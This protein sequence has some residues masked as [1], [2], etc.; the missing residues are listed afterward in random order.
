MRPRDRTF[1]QG[2]LRLSSARYKA[3]PVFTQS[4]AFGVIPV[5][6]LVYLAT[7][8][9]AAFVAHFAAAKTRLTLALWFWAMGSILVNMG[10]LP[11]E[12]GVFIK[13]LAEIGIIVIMFALVFEEYSS[14]FLRSIK[15]SWGIAVF[16]AIAPVMAT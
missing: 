10:F 1:C 12:P 15:R 11:V 5:E 4:T 8:W 14:A 3:V 16:G 7:I 13:D 9:A 2:L 6:Y